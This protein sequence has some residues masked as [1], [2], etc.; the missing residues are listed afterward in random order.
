M[1]ACGSLAS[2]Q[3]KAKPAGK[4]VPA[5]FKNKVRKER[6]MYVAYIIADFTLDVKLN[7]G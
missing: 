7:V 6:R 4:G 2:F 3:N 1:K 5:G